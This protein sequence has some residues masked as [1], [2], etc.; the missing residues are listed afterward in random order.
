[1]NDNKTEMPTSSKIKDSVLSLYIT[2]CYVN[3]SIY[4]EIIEEKN[5]IISFSHYLYE[6]IQTTNFNNYVGCD[7]EIWWNCFM[8]E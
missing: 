2:K 1:M 3:G 8:I 6:W 5:H 7:T 4:E